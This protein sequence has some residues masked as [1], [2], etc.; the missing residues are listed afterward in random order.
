MCEHVCVSM[1]VCVHVCTCACTSVCVCVCVLSEPQ[2]H[3]VTYH[4]YASVEWDTHAGYVNA[5]NCVR[6]RY[7]CGQMRSLACAAISR[8][9]SFPLPVAQW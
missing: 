7:S 8:L 4:I 1:C 5:P 3:V 9:A 2:L 6:E